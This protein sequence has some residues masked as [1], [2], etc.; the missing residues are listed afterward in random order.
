MHSELKR[1]SERERERERERNR[2]IDTEVTQPLSA[3]FCDEFTL[4]VGLTPKLNSSLRFNGTEL[5][6]IS[7][8]PFKAAKMFSLF[9][10]T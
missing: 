4:Y 10:L 3:K 9:N 2:E 8:F 5:A 7:T 1:E 6:M